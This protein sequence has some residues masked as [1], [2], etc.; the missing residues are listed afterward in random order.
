MRE[1]RRSTAVSAPE[2]PAAILRILLAAEH[3]CPRG[4]ARALY[5]LT[6]IAF[7]K[8]P[9]RGVF[10]PTCRGDEELFSAVER[11][12]L[13]HLE[14]ASARRAWHRALDEARLDASRRDLVETAA[15]ELQTASDTAYYYT[16][17]AFGLV[18]TTVSR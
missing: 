7:T 12:A 2:W 6:A 16:G 11:V 15:L 4:H 9:A 14:L 10:D 5:E 17:L 18:A 1:R 13:A 3:E 8:V